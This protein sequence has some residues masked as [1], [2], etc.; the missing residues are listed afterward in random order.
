ML[1]QSNLA[2]YFIEKTQ[3]KETSTIYYQNIYPPA[4]F[5]AIYA[6]LLFQ[7]LGHLG[8][9][10]PLDLYTRLCPSTPSIKEAA[11]HHNDTGGH[12]K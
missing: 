2:S 6:P 3:S 10:Q 5:S 11:H 9:D 1:T 12:F 4:S 8:E 7:W